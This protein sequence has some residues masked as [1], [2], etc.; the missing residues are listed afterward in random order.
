MEIA[1][2]VPG[3]NGMPVYQYDNTDVDIG[4]E[5]AAFYGTQS[6]Y[7]PPVPAAP[8]APEPTN[9]E[10]QQTMP[11]PPVQPAPPAQQT[12]PPP[13]AATQYVQPT[14]EQQAQAQSMSPEIDF[15]VY[16]QTANSNPNNAPT[17]G[18]VSTSTSIK[19]KISRAL[20][21]KKKN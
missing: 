13:P 18:S 7:S 11:P 2:F 8:V 3:D 19:S 21:R 12:Y 17:T 14:A 4:E 6:L 1:S 5:I 16:S 15:M 9:I 20:K 10:P